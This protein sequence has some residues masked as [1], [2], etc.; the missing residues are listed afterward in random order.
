MYNIIQ[1]LYITFN[2]LEKVIA[3][4]AVKAKSIIIIAS[5]HANI[6]RTILYLESERS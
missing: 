2:L 5:H 6:N 1:Y 3:I 4:V